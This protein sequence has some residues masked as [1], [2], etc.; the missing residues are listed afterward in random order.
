MPSKAKYYR[1]GFYTVAALAIW[2]ITSCGGPDTFDEHWRVDLGK[3]R[4]CT[5]V[6][7]AGGVAVMAHDNHVYFLD[8]ADGTVRWDEDLGPGSSDAL[9]FYDDLILVGNWEGLLLAID[10]L[11]GNEAWRMEIP[12]RVYS[13]LTLEGDTL[14]CGAGEKVYAVD[15]P[16]KEVLWSTLLEEEAKV[17]AK[18]IVENGR[19]FVQAGTHVFAL[20]VETGEKLWTYKTTSYA[21]GN[22]YDPVAVD[23]GRVLTG[24]PTEEF[25]GL[26]EDDGELRWSNPVLEEVWN[27]RLVVEPHVHAGR[28]VFAF[29][30]ILVLEDSAEGPSSEN[31]GRIMCLSA[32][33]GRTK[34]TYDAPSFGG[35]AFG[36]GYVYLASGGDVHVVNIRFG[37]G[38]PVPIPGK[39]TGGL[40]AIGDAVYFVVDGRYLVR[41]KFS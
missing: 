15:I 35:V 30:A 12:D 38:G 7:G 19:V 3:V 25:L 41:G 36:D 39:Y 28:V 2:T 34:W 26:D 4:H 8:L 6:E 17:W 18:P 10:P 40:T 20:G 33:N 23:G 11:S 37:R 1:L 27:N 31:V 9:C 24:S 22:Y 14:Y 16:N 21:G 32:R 29:D 5:V 13:P